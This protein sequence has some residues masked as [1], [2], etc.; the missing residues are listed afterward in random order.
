M[1]GERVGEE[2]EIERV[3]LKR[4]TGGGGRNGGWGERKGGED[5]YR[6]RSLTQYTYIVW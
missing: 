5:L 4:G 1:D 6:S 3:R 2:R